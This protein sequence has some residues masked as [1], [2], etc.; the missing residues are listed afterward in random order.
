[1]SKDHPSIGQRVR[2]KVRLPYPDHSYMIEG[3][4]RGFYK[5]HEGVNPFWSLIKADGG[6]I[7]TSVYTHDVRAL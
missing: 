1:M 5:G 7:C 2:A 3:E 4:Y 6:N